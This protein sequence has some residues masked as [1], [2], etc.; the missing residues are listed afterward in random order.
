M[1]IGLCTSNQRARPNPDAERDA[2]R[3]I[4]A[5]RGTRNSALQRWLILLLWWI[6]TACGGAQRAPGTTSMRVQSVTFEGVESFNP[7]DIAEVLQTRSS[8]QPNL[9]RPR[10]NPYVVATDIQRIETYY[11]SR[12]FLQ[13]RVVNYSFGEDESNNTARVHFVVDEGEPSTVRVFEYESPRLG[14]M[15]LGTLTEGITLG[16]G[17]RFDDNALQAARDLIRRRLTEASYAYARVDARVYAN[18]ATN[19]VEVYIFIDSGVSCV[20]GDVTVV[21]NRQIPS[22]RIVHRLRFEEGDLYRQSRLRLSQ[23]NL[24]EMGAFNFVSIDPVLSDARAALWQRWGT[25]GPEA[26]AS[27]AEHFAA[28]ES[29][30]GLMADRGLELVAVAS[31]WPD[32]RSADH[33]MA[34]LLD[35]LDAIE[36]VNNEVPITITVSENPGATYRVGGGL[37]IMA[38]R[39]ETYARGRATYR[40]ALA[41][42][43]QI[44]LDGR[45]GYA[46]LPSV[47]STEQT[48][49]G[50]IGKAQVG[51]SRPGLFNFADLQ[52]RISYERNLQDDYAFRRPSFT[53]GF[54]RRLS[55]YLTAQAGFSVDIMLTNDDLL[56]TAGSCQAV[57]DTF[58]LSRFDTSVAYDR[59]DNPLAARRGWFSEL[60]VQVGI[61]SPLGDFSYLR[62]LPDFRIYQPIGR[63]LTAAMRISGGAIIDFGNNVPRSQCLYLGGGDTVRGFPQ[64][65]L[66]PYDGNSA[67][68]GLTM[69]MFNI[70]PRVELARDWLFGVLFLDGGSVSSGELAFN[71]RPGGAEGLQLAAGA[72]LRIV[73]P[74]GPFRLDLGY[75]MTSAPQYDQYLKSRLAFFLS[76]GEA[77]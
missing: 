74:V 16:R 24:Y 44:D 46:W 4:L 61:R 25:P 27:R 30:D 9:R 38:G 17:T 29:H 48:I 70:E 77:F 45:L 22:D 53:V 64:R 33:R 72:G 18:R 69:Y 73:T 34:G 12:G 67:V 63:R 54:S 43:N 40:N 68:G 42:L 35:N 8:L 11:H 31:E 28:M 13:A 65:R 50:V 3:S 49:N 37:G 60:G 15:D 21:G 32:D 14:Q 23:L 41:P 26:Q 2:S 66:S 62:V 19:T 5:R 56:P 10:L 71:F 59:R 39:S 36:E 55:Q 47:F 1:N 57:P 20:F 52:T 7:I 75:R 76:I 6:L 51:F 58:R